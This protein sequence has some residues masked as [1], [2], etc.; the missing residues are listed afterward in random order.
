[1]TLAKLKVVIEASTKPYRD[2]LN[3]ATSQTKTAVNSIEKSVGRI[4]GIVAGALSVAALATFAKGCIE[5]GSDLAEVQNVVDVTFGKMSGAINK[6]AK[7]SIE[8]LGLS[9][10]SAKRYAS[11]MGAML[12]SMGVEQLGVTTEQVTANMSEDMKK[13]FKASGDAVADMSMALTSLSAD[14]ASFYNLESQEAFNKIRS[15]I[16]G[17]TEP[18]KQLGINMSVANLE[19]YALAQGIT[20]SYNAMTQQE[21]ALLRYNY[22][23]TVTKDAQGDF[24]RTSGG[25]ANQVRILTERFNSLRASIG[26]GLIAVLTPVVQ[27][28][29]QLL[30][31]ILTVTD[32]FNN[33][34]AKV[35]GS[36]K[37]TVTSVND[38]VQ[39][40]Q[41]AV[42][43]VAGLSD[44]ETDT[45][46]AAAD[47]A[48]KAAKAADAAKKKSKEATKSVMSFDR[49]NN[50]QKQPDTDAGSSGDS[51]AGAGSGKLPEAGGISGGGLTS[52]FVPTEAAAGSNK[53]LDGLQKKLESLKKAI[54]PTINALKRL[55]NEGLAKLGNFTWQALKDFYEHFLKPVGKWV[56]GEGLPRFIDALN[57]MLNKIDWEKINTALSDLWK[58]LAPFAINVGE[59]LLWFWENVLTPLGTWVANEVVPRFL[60]TLKNVISILNTVIEA[61]KPLWQWFW[62]NVLKPAAEWTGG[63]I[64]EVW[65]KLNAALKKF[66]DWCTEHKTT[67]ENI[68][69][70]IGSF[71]AAFAI[72]SLV[73]QLL[74][75]ITTAVTVVTSI[76]SISGALSLLKMGLG[77][78]VSALGG[79]VTIAIAAAIAIGVLLWKNWDTIKAK[80]SE[81]WEKI[82]TAFSNFGESVKKKATETWDKIKTS[83]TEFGTTLK[84]KATE[85]WNNV[86]TTFSSFASS[87]KTRASELWS[88]VKEIFGTFTEW[89]KDTFETDWSERFES[90]WGIVD[91]FKEDVSGIFD[92]VKE[93]FGD[94]V[95]FVNDVFSGDWKGAWDDIVELF[96][97]VWDGIG[98]AL[99]TPLN[100][101]IG[102]LNGFLGAVESMVNSVANMLNGLNIDAPQ[103]VTDLTGVTSIGFSLPTW[104]APTLDYLKE[105]GIT[106]ADLFAANENGIPELVGKIG[107]R[108]AVANNEQ[109]SDA[110]YEAVFDAIG[111]AMTQYGSQSG[112]DTVLMVDSEELARAVDRGKE[113]WSRR[114]NPVIVYV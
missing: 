42:P 93:I 57:N 11:T 50:L 45:G 46:A 44:A 20:K 47:A 53:V 102:V 101:A 103:W 59:G 70:V 28:L 61:L 34:I 69:I 8:T 73:T 74:T 67:I 113:K 63:V 76:H 68:T 64:T 85:T 16:S 15:G 54:E 84:T 25:W 108:T 112:G 86:K 49:I 22:L 78:I 62:D 14:M 6:F 114:S 99:K 66:S 1:M 48:K 43:A 80:C 30:A 98:D 87:L 72:V 106:S 110:L 39:A 104:T 33:L 88:K 37:S 111:D 23:L 41:A 109:I 71:F 81:I 40:A 9:E 2:Q 29:N 3:A 94:I 97:D 79:P 60:E 26:Q 89:I 36:G 7:E 24:A 32:A 4:K 27:V 5:L 77:T 92:D 95:S 105:G 100:L 65:D 96:E 12:K 107:H 55:R 18:L 31:K 58:E 51:G 21:Q 83:F 56:M 10:T 52:A 13:N 91:Q 35:T 75:F 90:L 38:T 19:A 82:K 17:E